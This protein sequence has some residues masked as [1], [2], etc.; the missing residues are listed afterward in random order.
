VSVPVALALCAAAIAVVALHLELNLLAPAP[1]GGLRVLMYHRIGDYPARD[2]VAVAELDRQIRW[3]KAQ[4]H[5]FVGF[6]D[7]LA[8]RA[9]GTPLPDRPVLLTFDD[10]T[11][12]H[13]E[14]LLPVLQRHQ[15]P[16]GLFVVSSFVG[17]EL[18][19]AG[20]LT[21]FLD[22]AM[23]GALVR[24]GVQIGLHSSTHRSFATLAPIEVEKE[25]AESFA[26]FAEHGIPVQPV[27]AYPFGAYPRKQPARREAFFATLRRGGIQLAFRIG[28]RV[29]PLPLAN[30][31]EI[32]R[33]GVRRADRLW[34]FAIKARKG[35]RKAL[36]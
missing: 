4:G 36:A 19:Y 9:H 15:I 30:D 10:G 22:A 27:L 1:R 17:R 25:I 33:I 13:F 23:L 31:F 20:R 28:N 24:A 35:R 21:P 6:S 7:L 18:E 16:A 26:F 2:S 29:N 8:H 11:R 5:S 32:T 34:S 14:H 3:L 12:D